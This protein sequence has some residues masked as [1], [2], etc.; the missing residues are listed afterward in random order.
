MNLKKISE[1]V[2][3][4]LESARKQADRVASFLVAVTAQQ[5]PGLS[6]NKIAAEIIT[7]NAPLGINTGI[8]PDGTENV[9]NKF[10]YN[11]VE[12]VIDSL[13]EDGLVECVI[14]SGALL[15]EAKGANAGGPIEAIGTNINNA[16]GY[17][18][19]R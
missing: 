3:N 2:D 9:V 7:D 18:I 5:R 10:V 12:K 4:A 17:G 8:M 1:I 16:K 19:I 11:V 14:P 6:R 13:K 15:V